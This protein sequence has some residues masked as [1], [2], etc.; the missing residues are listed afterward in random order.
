MTYLDIHQDTQ[1]TNTFHH[2]NNEVIDKTQILKW[3]FN[4]KSGNVIN[5]EKEKKILIK[6][7]DK[8]KINLK[9]YLL[10][11]EKLEHY[12]SLKFNFKH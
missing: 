10:F 12:V 6:I 9:K 7:L 1:S 4:D 3:A 11:T 5:L 2:A 8:N